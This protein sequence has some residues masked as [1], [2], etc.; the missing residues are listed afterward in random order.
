[1]DHLS[2]GGTSQG[3]TPALLPYTVVIGF[4]RRGST[5]IPAAA[6]SNHSTRTL[7]ALSSVQR[8][9]GKKQWRRRMALGWSAYCVR[10]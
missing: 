8:Y 1:V 2:R 6:A 4:K 9:K 10:R 7:Q 3:W 5:P